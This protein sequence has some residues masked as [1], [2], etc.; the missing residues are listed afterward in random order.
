MGE[1]SRDAWKLIITNALQLLGIGFGF[2]LA[3]AFALGRVMSSVLPGV[4]ALDPMVF[5]IFTVVLSATGFLAAYV[6]ARRATKAD[7]ILALR[8]E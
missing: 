1:Q 7:P 6:P 2:G 4:V 5:A 3:V 8:N